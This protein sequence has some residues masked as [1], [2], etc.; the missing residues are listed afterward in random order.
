[1][2]QWLREIDGAGVTGC[3]AFA[4]AAISVQHIAFKG[5]PEAITDVVAGRADF[6]IQPFTVSLALI[7]DGKLV[8][9]A[10]SAPKRTA[11]KPDVPTTVEAGLAADFVLSVL[12]RAVPARS[13][14]PRHRREAP[15]RSCRRV[16]DA[17]RARAARQAR[18]GAARPERRAV[19]QILPRRRQ[20]EPRAGQGRAHPAAVECL[21]AQTLEKFAE[22]GL[23]HVF[24]RPRCSEFPVLTLAPMWIDIAQSLIMS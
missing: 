22:I 21:S 3:P 15:R 4:G 1:M 10:V 6:S 17:E 11:L 16:G 14:P 12:E 7:N 19:R 13:H 8:A 24:D 23:S 18:R 5:A 2:G 20:G 9:L